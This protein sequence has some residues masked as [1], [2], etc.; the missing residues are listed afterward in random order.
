MSNETDFALQF[1]HRSL[2]Y[3]HAAQ[4]YMEEKR[5]SWR[6]WEMAGRSVRTLLEKIR[7][8]KPNAVATWGFD[9]GEILKDNEEYVLPA[10]ARANQNMRNLHI[11]GK[12]GELEDVLS[13]FAELKIT[14]TF[15]DKY[16]IGKICQIEQKYEYK[17]E[18]DQK[19]IADMP[20]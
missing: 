6:A 11:T 16:G 9:F 20:I 3:L 17:E 13:K 12:N 18:V 8:R 5:K 10:T 4:D 7:A 15:K 2:D 14:G 1:R 19:T